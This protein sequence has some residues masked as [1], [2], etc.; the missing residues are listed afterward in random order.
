MTPAFT[1]A[2]IVR[3]IVDGD[4]IRIDWDLGAHIWLR[5]VPVRLL[6]IDAPELRGPTRAAGIA[7]RD[8]LA[9]RLP[10]GTEVTI[11]TVKGDAFGR[12][13]AW[14]WV[15]ADL[16]NVDMVRAGHAVEVKA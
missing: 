4:T 16:I 6:G 5:D 10:I 9:A 8:W 1:Y 12:Y 15:G 11:N 3:R 2:A 14:V 7:A 13:L